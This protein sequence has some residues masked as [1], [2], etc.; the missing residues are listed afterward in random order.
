MF[1]QTPHTCDSYVMSSVFTVLSLRS[2]DFC[3]FNTVRVNSEKNFVKSILHV[4]QLQDL[5]KVIIP[6]FFIYADV[7][8]TILTREDGGNG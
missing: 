7:A 4:L 2:V 8:Y 6:V 1:L 3:S 5:H